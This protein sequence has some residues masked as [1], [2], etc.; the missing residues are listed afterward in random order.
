MYIPLLIDEMIK[1][2]LLS[3]LR[4]LVF[5]VSANSLNQKVK[6]VSEYCGHLLSQ[7]G[8]SPIIKCGNSVDGNIANSDVIFNIMR[9]G[10]LDARHL[11]ETVP[12]TLNTPIIGQ[13]SQGFGGFASA[14]RNIAALLHFKDAVLSNCPDTLFINITNPSGIMTEAARQLGINAVGICDVPYAMKEKIAAYFGYDKSKLDLDFIGLNHLSWITE[15][16]YNNESIL[17]DVLDSHIGNLMKEIK[18]SNIPDVTINAELYRSIRAIPSSYLY[19]YNN[20][21]ELICHLKKQKQSRAECV[22]E[23][24]K[25]TYESYA[26]KAPP[27]IFG[28]GRGAYLLGKAV[29]EFVR[30]YFGFDSCGNHIVCVPNGDCLPFLPKDKIIETGVSVKVGNIT[31]RHS[32]CG[33]CVDKRVADL[34]KTVSD[35]E[36]LTVRAGLTGERDAALQALTVHPLIG[37]SDE[38][39]SELLSII[40]E[41]YKEWLH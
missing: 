11:D 28:K 30:S 16:T 21:D 37:A 13:E 4:E 7:N 39:A 17:D 1:L 15:L 12:L 6:I 26:Q 31:S 14:L 5:I 24:D 29:A 27:D 19:Y 2:N 8:L 32:D 35:Y 3:D 22:K 38:T 20:T 25:K 36:R 10:G 40:E 9:S 23:N 18:Q 33:C 34:I 41:R